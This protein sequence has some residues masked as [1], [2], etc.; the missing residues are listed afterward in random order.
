[1]P[2]TKQLGFIAQTCSQICRVS[3]LVLAS[4][5]GLTTVSGTP[6]AT[7]LIEI[8]QFRP[9]KARR[10]L[11]IKAIQISKIPRPLYL[12]HKNLSQT[13]RA[14]L[15][16]SGLFSRILEAWQAETDGSEL[17]AIVKA[18]ERKRN[19]K[20]ND[21]IHLQFPNTFEIPL[22]GEPPTY[23]LSA[24]LKM[25]LL[26]SGKDF[27]DTTITCE[28]TDDIGAYQWSTNANDTLGDQLIEACIE[29]LIKR[30]KSNDEV[31]HALEKI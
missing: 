22:P 11:R 21:S 29:Q 7:E 4:L 23:Q 6:P 12:K 15:R 20:R 13:L 19:I 30:I 10:A 25:D 26:L 1:M 18:S 16:N 8:D 27:P 17:V 9:D 28:V 2:R 31:M 24:A 14:R 5:T 3:L